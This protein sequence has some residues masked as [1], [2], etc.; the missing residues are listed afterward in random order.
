MRGCLWDSQ[1]SAAESAGER[2]GQGCSSWSKF[3]GS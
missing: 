3:C 2:V 1:L